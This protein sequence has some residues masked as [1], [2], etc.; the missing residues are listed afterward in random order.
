MALEQQQVLF[1]LE[2]L[3]QLE[4]TYMWQIMEITRFVK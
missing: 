4:Q 1:F 3:Q 2:V